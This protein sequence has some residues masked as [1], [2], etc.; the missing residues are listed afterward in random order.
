MVALSLTVIRIPRASFGS[1]KS[2]FVV[3]LAWERPRS[4]RQARPRG[5]S[6]PGSSS[7]SRQ[8]DP[9]TTEDRLDFQLKTSRRSAPSA[10][11]REP[12]TSLSLRRTTLDRSRQ[13]GPND[14]S[15]WSHSGLGGTGG[16]PDRRF[17]RA[18]CLLRASR[19][20]LIG[21]THQLLWRV[22]GPMVSEGREAP[23]FADDAE[24]QGTRRHLAC[25]SSATPVMPMAPPG[26][27][28]SVVKVQGAK[29]RRRRTADQVRPPFAVC[30]RIPG[31]P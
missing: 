25:L 9:R 1:K 20:G 23:Q 26:P 30:H 7:M 18:T 21:R 12:P 31:G 29:G 16:R 28:T 19:P 5:P 17:A 14:S 6:G 4:R 3:P 2:R 10:L 13:K 27:W 8:S 11:R 15:V 24:I 22:P